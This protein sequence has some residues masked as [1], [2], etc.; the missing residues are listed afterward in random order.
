MRR[1]TL[2]FKTTSHINTWDAN[3]IALALP[4]Y[5]STRSEPSS[6]SAIVV[7]ECHQLFG[8]ANFIYN[9]QAPPW[10]VS[11]LWPAPWRGCFCAPIKLAGPP[12]RSEKTHYYICLALF[13]FFAC[14]NRASK[15]S[16][17]FAR[18]RNLH[19]MSRQHR[20]T[21]QKKYDGG[22]QKHWARWEQTNSLIWFFE[23]SIPVLNK[24]QDMSKS[25]FSRE[26]RWKK[27]I[28]TLSWPVKSGKFSFLIPRPYT[29][30]HT[31][32]N[33]VVVKQQRTVRNNSSTR[34]VS[35]MSV[36]SR[37]S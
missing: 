26:W 12:L 22:M 18:W 25:W 16:V 4:V 32:N 8:P 36:K 27:S 21:K 1:L 14:G 30:H 11:R 34:T 3:Q 17:P 5:D 9:M 13:A 7:V 2:S 15:T 28:Y 35:A 37:P 20:P 19:G 33:F 29:W 23:L 10:S 6:S 31:F 24:R